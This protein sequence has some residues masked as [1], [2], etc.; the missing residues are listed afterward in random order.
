MSSH[1]FHSISPPTAGGYIV[2]TGE[3][4]SDGGVVVDESISLAEFDEH[5]EM[6]MG[7]ATHKAT[8][9]RRITFTLGGSQRISP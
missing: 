2:V 1:F 4:V 7:I 5:A 6:R 3:T 9:R 8:S